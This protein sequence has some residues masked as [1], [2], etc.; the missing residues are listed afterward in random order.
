MVGIPLMRWLY[1]VWG[2]LVFQKWHLSF[3]FQ[4]GLRLIYAPFTCAAA[5]RTSQLVPEQLWHCVVH[6]APLLHLDYLHY[7]YSTY[8]ETWG[9]L[10][11]MGQM[12]KYS[13]K[14]QV[15]SGRQRSKREKKILNNYSH[16]EAMNE[17]TISGHGWNL[18]SQ[19]L[20]LINKCIHIYIYIYV[21]IHVP[22]LLYIYICVHMCPSFVAHTSHNFHK[23]ATNSVNKPLIP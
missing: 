23:C 7:I 17:P 8:L 12:S 1:W 22:H 9:S 21:Y 15:V 18:W 19:W 16:R 3:S 6:L 10:K 4:T 11:R 20:I 13:A 2:L 14:C 5:A